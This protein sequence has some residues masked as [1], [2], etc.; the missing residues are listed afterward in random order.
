[1][2]SETKEEY[3]NKKPS[4][5]TGTGK[6][7]DPDFQELQT[8]RFRANKTY[9]MLTTGKVVQLALDGITAQMGASISDI[10]IATISVQEIL[11]SAVCYSILFA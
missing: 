6:A 10:Q 2:P 5:V 9:K 7:S 11:H 4:K 8:V 3:K 1:M